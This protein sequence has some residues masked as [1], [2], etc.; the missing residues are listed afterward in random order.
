MSLA[1]IEIKGMVC[2]ACVNNIQDTIGARNGIASIS[3]SLEDE[4]G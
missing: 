1:I 4:Q 2:H 3:V